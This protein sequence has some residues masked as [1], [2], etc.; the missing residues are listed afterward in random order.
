MKELIKKLLS[1]TGYTIA[2]LGVAR[3]PQHE[4]PLQPKHFFDLY[5]S[6]V[7]PRNF[8]FVHI[9]ANDGLSRDLLHEYITAYNLK[10]ILVEPQEEIF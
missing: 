9:G 10:G 2:K 8:F 4:L 3:D 5:F 6:L 1:P 7:N